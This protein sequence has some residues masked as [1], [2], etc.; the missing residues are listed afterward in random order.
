MPDLKVQL[1]V[2]DEQKECDEESITHGPDGININSHL[3]VFYAVL[4]QVRIQNKKI[5]LECNNSFSLG[6]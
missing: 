1:N 6:G 5:I 2:F 3:D 4:T